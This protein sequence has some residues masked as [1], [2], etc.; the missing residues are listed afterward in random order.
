MEDLN[1]TFFF[2]G[3]NFFRVIMNRVKI[4]KVN[5]IKGE[6]EIINSNSLTNS[7]ILTKFRKSIYC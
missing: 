6:F 2:T 3:M 4:I 5:I 7:V 1:K